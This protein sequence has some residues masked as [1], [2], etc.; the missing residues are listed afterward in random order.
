MNF[1]NIRN[2]RHVVAATAASNRAFNLNKPRHQHRR[3]ST[4][5]IRR[6]MKVEYLKRVG[7]WRAA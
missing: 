6:Q 1:R 4:S 5:G 7:K 3:T 2:I